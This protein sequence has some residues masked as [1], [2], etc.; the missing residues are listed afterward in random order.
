MAL[1]KF[2][3]RSLTPAAPAPLLLWLLVAFALPSGAS[4]QGIGS[5]RGEIGGTG[6]N[7]VIQGQITSP[8]GSLP[9]TRVRITLDI[10][11]AGSRSAVADEE[12]NFTFSNL[13]NGSHRL[14]V[15]AGPM[16]EPAT[17]SV[18]IEGEKPTYIVAIYLRPKP[19]ANP[20]FAGVP[21][22]AI[23]LFMKAQDAA[24]KKDSKKAAEH[25]SAAVAAHPQFAIAHKE[26]GVQ[27]LAAGQVDKAVE[28]LQTAVKL[29]P[30]DPH[31]Q[32]NYGIALAQKKDFAAAEP[33]L[34]EALKKM[35]SSA[36]GHMYLGVAL[37]GLKRHDEAE[38]ELQRAVKLGGDRM[39]AA[40]KYLGGI[41]WGRGDLRRAAEELETYVKLMPKAPDAEKIKAT[42]KDL[43]AK[44]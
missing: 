42:A 14:T 39:G 34:R 12:G 22:Q 41:Y 2:R 30:G 13:G 9:D 26:L 32:L 15:D 17:E 10:P 24:R 16:Y 7:R 3:G 25:L 38:A 43:R 37:I 1:A 18:F 5:H 21:K 11:S 6:G 28:S 4:A 40:H 35:D 31:A 29:A 27:F 36:Q 20:A 44:L 23:D 19:E 33:P 8:L